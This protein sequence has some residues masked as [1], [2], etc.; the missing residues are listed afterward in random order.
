MLLHP[1]F[2]LQGNS[3]EH[4]TALLEFSKQF[5]EETHAFLQEWF[6]ENGSITVSTSGS[7]GPPKKIQLPKEFMINSAKATGQLF[8]LAANT[9]ALLCLPL[10]YIAGKMMLVRALVL[11]W[12]IDIVKPSSTPLEGLET[13]YD[14]T[15]MVPLQLKA[16]VSELHK[17][18]TLIVGGGAVSKDVLK[19]LQK[20]P[21]Q[22]YA[23]YGMTETITHIAVKKISQQDANTRPIYSALP[24]VSLAVDERQCL[25]IDAPAVSKTRIV[26]N[27]MVTLLS[28]TSFEWLG[29]ID[30]VINSGGIKIHPE[31]LEEKL[32]SWMP[33]RFFFWGV[34]DDNLGQKLLLLVESNQEVIT[35][36]ALVSSNLLEKY[37]VPKEIIHIPKFLETESGKIQRLLTWQLYNDNK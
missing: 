14:F 32:Q 8:N 33:S 28:K 16:S 11:G 2:K 31:I 10:S 17:I 12:N 18:K 15:A 13:T 7:T 19:A 24:G 3:F 22:V 1:S 9:N 30:N 23:T 37:E 4:Q 35:K 5:D 34:Q 25:L 6:S 29:R 21:T 27:D 36:E 20:V 26:T